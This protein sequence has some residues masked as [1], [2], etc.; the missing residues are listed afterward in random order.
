MQNV[1]ISIKVY[2]IYFIQMYLK[3]MENQNFLFILNFVQSNMFGLRGFKFGHIQTIFWHI[4][5]YISDGCSL[6]FYYSNIFQCFCLKHLYFTVH[7]FNSKAFTLY[8]FQMY[9]FIVSYLPCKEQLADLFL[10]EGSTQLLQRI[11]FL[12]VTKYGSY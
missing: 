2:K 9:I 6:H 8:I 10:N 7:L 3:V 1:S 12:F 5:T 4:L 11:Q